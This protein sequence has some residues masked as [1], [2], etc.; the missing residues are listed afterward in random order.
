MEAART[1]SGRSARR[2]P[3]AGR[4]RSGR[5]RLRDASDAA[6]GGVSARPPACARTAPCARGAQERRA[7]Q[8]EPGVVQHLVPVRHLRK[9]PRGA[10][11]EHPLH[12]LGRRH[13][14]LQPVAHFVA[15]V[16]RREAVGEGVVV[17]GRLRGVGP[18]HG[19]PFQ[20]VDPV[21]RRVRGRRLLVRG[22]QPGLQRRGHARL[23]GVAS[24]FTTVLPL[25]LLPRLCRSTPSRHPPAFRRICRRRERVRPARPNRRPAHT[26]SLALLPKSSAATCAILGR[27][28]LC[29]ENPLRAAQ[30]N[31]ADNRASGS[32][33][34]CRSA[35]RSASSLG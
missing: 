21:R 19:V 35:T 5:T 12:G 7:T 4:T 23:G 22:G 1:P 31:A 13:V 14:L 3:G 28:M 18:V 26:H 8:L 30:T 17:R 11:E 2:G 15:D 25:R 29:A 33:G 34:G 16:R 24:W 27:A 9:G 32:R 10:L 20:H 6:R